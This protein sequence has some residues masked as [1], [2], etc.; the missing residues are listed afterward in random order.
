MNETPGIFG[1]RRNKAQVILLAA[2]FALAFQQLVLSNRESERV[3]TQA[4]LT[5]WDR[6]NSELASKSDVEPAKLYN[7]AIGRCLTPDDYIVQ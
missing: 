4:L 5:L 3:K 7:A 1:T 6:H 2:T